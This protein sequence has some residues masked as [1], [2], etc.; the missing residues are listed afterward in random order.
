MSNAL[1][2]YCSAADHA[3]IALGKHAPFSR[4]PA[5]YL[6]VDLLEDEIPVDVCVDSDVVLYAAALGVQSSQP[7][8]AVDVFK[9]NTFAPILLAE[10]LKEN[11]FKGKLVTFGSYAEIG[12]TDD[13]SKRYNEEDLLLSEGRIESD[14]CLSKRLL[15]KYFSNLKAPFLFYHYILPTIYG[16]GE[17]RNRLI[18]YLIDSL[19]NNTP[20]KLTAGH[21]IRQYLLVQNLIEILFECIDKSIPA[22]IYN[23]PSA[24]TLS[25]K[26]LVQIVFNAAQKQ[27]KAEVFGTEQRQD[28][29]NR[30]L[31]L[32]SKKISALVNLPKLTTVE[33]FVSDVLNSDKDRN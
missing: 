6:A 9:V 20:I 1:I 18:P 32:D 26:A 23:I 11:A 7:A 12:D 8:K 15:S 27:L 30:V 5:N 24:E 2:E 17:N 21:Q 28:T 4:E 14:Y 19:V 16:K 3:V 31:Q 25:I 22:G 10:K 13:F 29:S 33:E